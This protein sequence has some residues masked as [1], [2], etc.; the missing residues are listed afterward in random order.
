MS[1]FSADMMR[2][3]RVLGEYQHHDARRIDSSHNGRRPAFARDNVSR[4]NPA[5]D[6]GRLKFVT[7]GVGRQFVFARMADKYVVRHRASVCS[8]DRCEIAHKNFSGARPVRAWQ[9][10]RNDCVREHDVSMDDEVHRFFQPVSFPGLRAPGLVPRNTF[11][12]ETKG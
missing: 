2:H 3:V 4:R 5:T 7:D 10:R 11:L 6:A 1:H 9:L 8:L 12:K